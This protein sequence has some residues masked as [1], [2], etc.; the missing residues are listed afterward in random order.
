VECIIIDD[1]G[2]ITLS[3]GMDDYFVGF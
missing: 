1:Y 2:D 3:S